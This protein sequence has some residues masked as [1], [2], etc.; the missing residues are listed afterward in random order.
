MQQCPFA[1]CDAQ[2][3]GTDILSLE[4]VQGCGGED[5]TGSGAKLSKLVDLLKRQV[6][7]YERAIVFTQYANI[8]DEIFNVLKA[9]KVP[10]LQLKGTA[11]QK[12]GAVEKFQQ[13][14]DA[15]VVPRFV[16][17]LSR[18]DTP[19]LQVGLYR[20]KSK[21]CILHSYQS[22]PVRSLKRPG[23]L[24]TSLLALRSTPV[25]SLTRAQSPFFAAS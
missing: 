6:K 5:G 8:E 12:S 21:C 17:F 19:S 11:H 7:S 13:V 14:I 22:R 9:A 25:S 15:N 24:P 16:E 1:G 10:C 4:K 3:R 20:F 2:M 23:R 18:D